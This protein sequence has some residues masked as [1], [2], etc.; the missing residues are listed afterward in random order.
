[1]DKGYLILAQNNSKDDYLKMAYVAAMSIKITQQAVKNVTLITDVP[2]AVPD[3]YREAFDLILPIIWYDDA[4]NSEWKIENRWKLYHMTPYEST[5]ILDADM[6]F[7]TDISNW[8]NYLDKH[9]DL[10]ITNKVM[11]YRNEEITGNYYRKV[12]TSNNLPNAY[13]AFTYFKKSKDAEIFWKMVEIITK[14]WKEF[15]QRYLKDDRPDHLSMDVVFALAIK[16]LEYE[17]KVFTK[18][19]YPT[20][21]HMKGMIQNW[22]NENVN[23]LS[24]TGVYLNDK[25]QL[26]IGNYYQEGVFHYTEK[27]FLN[28]NVYFSY[29]RLFQEMTR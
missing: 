1:M 4:L 26:K 29:Q 27:N 21:T 22:R 13:S 23:W 15:Y 18:F 28:D 16:L 25:C 17:D 11:T 7:L 9:H 5:V 12:F 2:D 14:N 8:W 6:L 24:A 3:H 10:F 19:K 20:F